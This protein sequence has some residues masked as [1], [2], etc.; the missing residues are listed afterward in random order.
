[1]DNPHI[2][3]PARKGTA[4]PLLI[5]AAI[6]VMLFCAVGIAA[7]MGWI[8]SHRAGDLTAADRLAAAPATAPYAGSEAAPYATAQ[9]NSFANAAGV[10]AAPVATAP[11]APVMEVPPSQAV[12]GAALAPAAVAATAPARTYEEPVHKGP[13]VARVDDDPPAR[14]WCGNCG[15]IESIR[16]V[17]T[18]ARG[19]GVGAAGGAVLGGLLGN[20]IGGGTGRTLATAAGAIGGAVVGNQVEGNVR[21]TK[22]YEIRVRLDDGTV[23][24]FH[25]QAAPRWRNGE[26]V[27]I[28]KGSIRAV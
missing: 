4:H 20:Q 25:Q 26:R 17:T 10:P 24:T 6:A 8:P 21:A 3:T 15:N 23:R 19:S 11:A 18:R 12:A 27:K 14:K 13:K 22:S 2:P 9:G 7:I 28:V 16:E 5:A 1:M